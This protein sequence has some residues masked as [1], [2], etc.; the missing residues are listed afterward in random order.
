[1]IST[2]AK[3]AYGLAVTTSFVVTVVSWHK[4]PTAVWLADRG[5]GLVMACGCVH[6]AWALR[7]Y[8]LA[9]PRV[10]TGIV[11]GSVVAFLYLPIPI[12][13]F[14]ILGLWQGWG[15]ACQV[16]LAVMV[17]SAISKR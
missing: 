5:L 1:M 6:M 9:V 2:R 12:I 4:F 15:Y 14:V 8:L 11:V 17:M 7:N 16:A 3:L 10:A 13:G